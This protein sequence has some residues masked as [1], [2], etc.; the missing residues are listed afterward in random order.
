[1]KIIYYVFFHENVIFESW[2]Y[3]I[4]NLGMLTYLNIII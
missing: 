4:S 1:M 2:H 3:N